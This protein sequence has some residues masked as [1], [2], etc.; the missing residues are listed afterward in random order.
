MSALVLG[1]DVDRR[2][3]EPLV[4]SPA[5]RFGAGSVVRVDDASGSRSWRARISYVSGEIFGLRGPSDADQMFSPRDIVTLHIGR[6]DMMLES[7]ARVLT[8]SPRTLRVLAKR[9]VGA[10]ER[11]GAVRIK[12]SQE[13][14]V[15]TIDGRGGHAI[16][17]QLIDL[18]PAGCAFRSEEPLAVG[19]RVVVMTGSGC[20]PLQL[21][22]EIV[23]VWKTETSDCI[24]AGV[25][26]D[27]VPQ[28]AREAVNRFL[29]EQVR[30]TRST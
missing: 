3:A 25:Q 24:H 26:F 29:V 28:R 12:M 23:R 15:R 10:L 27:P 17:A 7:Q 20:V 5:L 13:L 9:G 2:A 19:S 30:R 21:V 16:A 22:G 1:R 18:S 8:A 4:R 11:R 6:D 14:S